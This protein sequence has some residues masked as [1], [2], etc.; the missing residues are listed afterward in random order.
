MQ[1]LLLSSST[2]AC[3]QVY[4]SSKLIYKGGKSLKRVH[5][6]EVLYMQSL[7]LSS[8]TLTCVQVRQHVDSKGRG[9]RYCSVIVRVYACA[10]MHA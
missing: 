4:N 2:L 8:S 6:R 10:C 7:F 3:V 5:T 1:S 9:R